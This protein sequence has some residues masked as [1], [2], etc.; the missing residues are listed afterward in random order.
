[1]HERDVETDEVGQLAGRVDLCLMR[2]LRLAEHRRRVHRVAPGA[3]EQLRRAKEDG[4]ALFPGQAVPVLPRLAGSLDRPLDLRGAALV[5]VGED[6]VLVVWH[7]RLAR[8]ARPHVFSSDHARD[9]E[10]LALHLLEA[11]AQARAM[12]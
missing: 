1:V 2:R 6:V 5:D 4:R 11:N 3:G 9:L 7:D 8:L 10:A 12:R